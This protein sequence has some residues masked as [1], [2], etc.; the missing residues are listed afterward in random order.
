[1]NCVACDTT[2][3]PTHPNEVF[4]SK[5]C[6]REHGNSLLFLGTTTVFE[7]EYQ[8]VTK[9]REAAENGLLDEWKRQVQNA[10]TQGGFDCPF[11][12]I[13]YEFLQERNGTR[14]VPV[15]IGRIIRP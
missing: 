12:E 8:I 4:C 9:T 11:D 14:V 5:E 7:Y 1:M 10:G 6:D 15:L 3:T 2:F 13:D